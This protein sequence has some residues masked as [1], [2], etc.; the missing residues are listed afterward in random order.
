MEETGSGVHGAAMHCVT[1]DCSDGTASDT[2][3]GCTGAGEG[4]AAFRLSC[5]SWEWQELRVAGQ[6]AG[7]RQGDVLWA[8]QGLHGAPRGG[9]VALVG[10]G[11][12]CLGFGSHY[13]P[14]VL[15]GTLETCSRGLGGG[16]PE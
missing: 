15:T 16:A 10:G 3:V 12:V 14:L 8:R 6:L 5:S 2:A 13:N 7:A 4:P 1:S 11:G 9:G